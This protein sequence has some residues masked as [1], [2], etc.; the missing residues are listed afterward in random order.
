MDDDPLIYAI[1]AALRYNDV[2]SRYMTD[3]ITVDSD[4]VQSAM[5][6]VK[7]RVRVSVSNRLSFYKSVNSELIVHDIYRKNVKVNELERV[8]WTR[9]RLSSHSLAVEKGRWNRRGR[10]RLP[11][12]ERL[13]SCGVIQTEMHVF[14]NCPISSLVR[15][16]NNV[17]TVSN[18]F[19]DR[20]DYINV[21]RI[22]HEVLALY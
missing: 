5:D 7:T 15:E 6:E 14:E 3:L 10:G 21:C 18:L 1:K 13:C 20:S 19:V 9:L 16:R 17:T 12:Q 8:S 11:M 2:V 22:V 4:D